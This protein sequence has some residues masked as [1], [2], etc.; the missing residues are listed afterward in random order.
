[1]YCKLSAIYAIFCSPF[2]EKRAKAPSNYGSR[3][4]SGCQSGKPERIVRDTENLRLCSL[5]Y[6]PEASVN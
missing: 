6:R 4:F 2:T 5:K 1:M 3:G